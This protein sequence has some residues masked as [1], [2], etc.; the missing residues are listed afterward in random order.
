MSTTNDTF[1]PV[2]L[3]WL[4]LFGLFLLLLILLACLLAPFQPSRFADAGR[5]LSFPADAQGR[6]NTDSHRNTPTTTPVLGVSH[7]TATTDSTRPSPVVTAEPALMVAF[8]KG[9]QAALTQK[10]YQGAV[11]IT[12]KGSGQATGKSFSDAFYI[13]T[14]QRGHAITPTRK[15]AFATLCIDRKPASAFAQSVPTYDKTHSYT[16]TLNAPGG[17]L[18]FGVCDDNLSDNTGSFTITFA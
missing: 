17:Q 7:A 13:Y 10:A 9:A 6:T 14:D 4:A 2:R 3:T 15:P 12:V 5:F 1:S 11:T 16:V 8:N 18:T